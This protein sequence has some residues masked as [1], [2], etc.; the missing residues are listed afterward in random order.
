V[1]FQRLLGDGSQFG[2]SISYTRQPSPDGLAQALVLG[3]EFLGAESVALVLG[4]NIF[5]GPGLGA[6]L[7]RFDGI[8]GGAVFAYRV[9]DPTAYGVVEFDRDFR[10]VSLEE[11]PKRP[12]SPYAVPGLYYCD[13]DVVEIAKGLEPSARGEYE[14]TDV[15]RCYLDRGKLQVEAL[16]GV[17]HGWILGRSTHCWRPDPDTAAASASGRRTPRRNDAP[18]NCAVSAMREAPLKNL[19]YVRCHSVRALLC[20]DQVACACR[21][22]WARYGVG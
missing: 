14:I 1:Q 17:L 18:P 19:W 4:D 13:N 7:T 12:R 16:P 10:A 20:L 15:N 11:K 22:E 3:E 5:Y 9:A 21:R 2:T 6:Q 8:D